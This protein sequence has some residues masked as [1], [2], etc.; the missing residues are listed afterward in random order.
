MLL[1]A[2]VVAFIVVTFRR[3]PVVKVDLVTRFCGGPVD[4]GS[5]VF[6]LNGE[7]VAV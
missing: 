6:A 2:A 3:A 5:S 4:S 7:K 1:V